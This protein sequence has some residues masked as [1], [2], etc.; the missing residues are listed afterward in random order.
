MNQIL[1]QI[2]QFLR[3]FTP[4]QRTIILIVFLGVISSIVTLIFWANRPEYLVLYGDLQP[5]QASKIL[6]ELNDK[7]IKYRLDNNGRTIKIPAQHISEM[8]LNLAEKGLTGDVMV[9]GYSVFDN[10]RIG[11]TSFMQQLN[12]KR[13]MEGELVKSINQFPSIKNCRV[14]LVLPE[15]KLFEEEKNGSASV[16][17]F[18]QDGYFL[19]ETQVKGIEM[20][21]ANSV[22]GIDR[23]NVVIVDSK[24][25]IL[26]LPGDEGDISSAGNHWELRSNIEDKLKNKVEFIVENIVGKG[27]S[28]VQVSAELNMD[29]LE[30]VAKRV[31]PENVAVISEESQI[32]TRTNVDTMTNNLNENISKENII[33]NYET[34]QIEERYVSGTGTLKRV[35]IAVLLNGRYKNV[36]D[37]EG[38]T[39]KEYEP[40]TTEELDYITNL[41][42]GAI[43][44]DE[45][46]GDL[47]EVQT[48]QFDQ[49]I[50]DENNEYF[51]KA[52]R[53]ELI[54]LYAK[55]LIIVLTILFAFLMVKKLTNSSAEVLGISAA[56]EQ[57]EIAEGEKEAKLLEHKE[58]KALQAKQRILEE[59]EIDENQFIMHLSPEAKARL[60]AKEKMIN[61]VRDFV[62]N[63][64]ED[65]AQLFRLW[66]NTKE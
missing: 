17:L 32:E 41:V 35:S 16:V 62:T 7:K 9:E 52:E 36:E 48:L 53:N 34:A 63:N 58:Q 31:D 11:M 4:L 26:S 19:K 46:R 45:N 2:I 12:M 65:A 28:V 37:A 14:H 18:L 24:G 64:P 30:R 21:V 25:N 60:K 61:T 54:T 49:S 29:R 39:T 55:R 33:T 13:A 40:R 20:L 15:E 43:G 5:T 3:K 22:K 27:N 6:T 57:L 66:I 44:Y 8:R 42:R 59:E 47:I 10:Q 1:A 50:Q 38:K 51:A 23:E 56:Q